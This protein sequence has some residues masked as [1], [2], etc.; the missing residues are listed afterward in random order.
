[1]INDAFS[2][3]TDT[4]KWIVYTFPGDTGKQA[5]GVQQHIV[6]IISFHLTKACLCE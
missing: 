6:N 5:L 3:N 2:N 1:M 4:R